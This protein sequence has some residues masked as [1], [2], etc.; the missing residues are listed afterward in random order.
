MSQD[1]RGVIKD[2]LADEINLVPI[3]TFGSVPLSICL[4]Y[5]N[6]YKLGMSNLGFHSI[7][8]YI[9]HREDAL[10]HRAFYTLSGDDISETFALESGKSAISTIL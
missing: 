10:C 9:N 5:P 4:A 7:Y 1:I 2:I 8:Y 6:S 3:K